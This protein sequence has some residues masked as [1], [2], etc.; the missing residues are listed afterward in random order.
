MII[1]FK[2]KELAWFKGKIEKESL[3]LI[4]KIIKKHCPIS[5]GEKVKT[6][7]YGNKV[8]WLIVSEISLLAVDSW[9]YHGEKLSFEYEGLPLKKNGE[10]MK[11]RKP[12][13]FDH[14]EKKGKIYGTPSYSRLTVVPAN[15]YRRY[16]E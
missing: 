1:E 5:V 10:P 2:S 7:T 4:A 13:R 9:G 15:M 3:D 14:F 11:S 6:F 16:S 12:V 8:E